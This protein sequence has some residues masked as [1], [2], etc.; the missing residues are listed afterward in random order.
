MVQGIPPGTGPS[1]P[2]DVQELQTQCPCLDLGWPRITQPAP[3]WGS[4]RAL[5]PGL[6]EHKAV[7]CC[8]CCLP[9]GAQLLPAGLSRP[10]SHNHLGDSASQLL[11]SEAQEGR[12]VG[13]TTA[14]PPVACP[15]W[16]PHSI[17]RQEPTA[18]SELGEGS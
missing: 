9:S 1:G 17:A 3:S 13:Q 11:A 18:G 6:Q 10:A 8:S 16:R 4:P 7:L 2:Q 15:E 14:L 5:S 12:E